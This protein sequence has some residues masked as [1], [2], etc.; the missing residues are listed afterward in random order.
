VALSLRNQAR[1]AILRHL[2]EPDL[3][4]QRGML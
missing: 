2:G 3:A 1:A 4:L